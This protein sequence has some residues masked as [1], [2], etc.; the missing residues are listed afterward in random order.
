MRSLL[1]SECKT[2]DLQRAQFRVK[3]QHITFSE[4]RKNLML[5]VLSI[6]KFVV[7]WFC[8]ELISDCKT[9]QSSVTG[10]TTKYCCCIS[11]FINPYTT[12]R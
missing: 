10:D 8:M 2:S 4:E 1:Q 6:I 9:R 3:S 5:P 11:L 7:H 12:H